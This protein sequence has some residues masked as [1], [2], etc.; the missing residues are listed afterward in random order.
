MLSRK[1]SC[2]APLPLLRR[3][4]R[5]DNGAAPLAD[6]AGPRDF[7]GDGKANIL[8]TNTVTH[9]KVMWLMN[10]L[11]PSS[12]YLRRAIRT[13]GTAVAGRVRATVSITK[14]AADDSKSGGGESLSSTR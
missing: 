12:G 6:A 1:F 13:V 4:C 5:D 3:A 14:N 7:N 2:N 10:G 8:F 11:S 9:D